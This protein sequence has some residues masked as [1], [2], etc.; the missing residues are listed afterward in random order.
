MG[1]FL[2]RAKIVAMMAICALGG[3]PLL[4]M[5]A[6]VSANRWYRSENDANARLCALG[7]SWCADYEKCIAYLVKPDLMAGGNS[8]RKMRSHLNNVCTTFQ[9]FQT[10]A[11]VFDEGYCKYRRALNRLRFIKEKGEHFCGSLKD[12]YIAIGDSKCNRNKVIK[13]TLMHK[14]EYCTSHFMTKPF[15]CEKSDT[16]KTCYMHWAKRN[17]GEKA[18]RLFWNFLIRTDVMNNTNFPCI[19]LSFDL[20]KSIDDI[21]CH[22]MGNCLPSILNR[23]PFAFDHIIKTYAVFI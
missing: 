17:C 4:L 23:N 22:R 21:I 12:D 11:A 18:A 14:F 10:C 7:M 5:G 8:K 19:V 16:A 13:A 15:S 1:T 20:G 3:L 6:D 9:D 2:L